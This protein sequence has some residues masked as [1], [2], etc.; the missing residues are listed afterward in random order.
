MNPLLRQHHPQENLDKS[1]E[2]KPTAKPNTFG[3]QYVCS[4]HGTIIRTGITCK[5][6]AL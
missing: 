1:E 4:E 2:A 6:I 5:K 3:C